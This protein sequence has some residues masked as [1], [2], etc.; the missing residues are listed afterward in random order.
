[1]TAYPHLLAPLDLGFTTLRNRVI[2]GS[3]HTGLEDRFYQL[4]QAGRV[5]P[6][7]GAGRRGLIVTGGISP[8]R[9]GWLLPFGGTLNFKATCEP[10]QGDARRARGGRQDRHA[11]PACG[12]LWLSAARGV[13]VGKN[14]R[15]RRSSRAPERAG[16][17]A[18]HPRLRAL[19]ALGA[20]PA[21]TAWK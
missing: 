18:H 7:T 12:P 3:M 14:R 15:S 2:M 21:T 9:Q 4:W 13:G 8:N 10:P 11:D 19:R 5:L 20:T 1:M 16:H 6:R 17:R